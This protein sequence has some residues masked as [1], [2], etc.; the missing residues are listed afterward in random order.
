MIEMIIET[1]SEIMCSL[2]RALRVLSSKER[3]WSTLWIVYGV[4]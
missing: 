2:L 1:I 3:T 4:D